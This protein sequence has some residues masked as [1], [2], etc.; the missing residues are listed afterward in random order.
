VPENDNKDPTDMTEVLEYLTSAPVEDDFLDHETTEERI[1]RL[2]E[3]VAQAQAAAMLNFES[4]LL[5]INIC[6]ERGFEP[7]PGESMP[8]TKPVCNMTVEELIARNKEA[9][10]RVEATRRANNLQKLKPPTQ[11][12]I[13]EMYMPKEM[14]PAFAALFDVLVSGQKEVSFE[15]ISKYIKA[16]EESQS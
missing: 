11:D 13:D 10:A 4:L 15:Q 3:E 16:N 14:S 12:Q 5:L 1:N 6:K 2:E 8:L 7:F 9:T